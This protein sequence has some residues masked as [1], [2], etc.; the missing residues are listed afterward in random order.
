MLCPCCGSRIERPDLPIDGLNHIRL[1]PKQR[2]ILGVIVESYPKPVTA[3]LLIETLYGGDPNGG[4]LTVRN[5]LA[6][7]VSRI[8]GIIEP[9]G[10]TVPLNRKGSG[11]TGLYRLEKIAECTQ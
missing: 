5:V 2:D 7:H 9:Y 3:E 8:R 4:P 6:V 1:T 10:W 11:N